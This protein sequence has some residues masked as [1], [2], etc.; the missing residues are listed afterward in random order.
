MKKSFYMNTIAVLVMVF[1]SFTT[2]FAKTLTLPLDVLSY[3]IENDGYY[4]SLNSDN[5]KVS[6]TYD[7]DSIDF[8]YTVTKDEVEKVYST[9][10]ELK[11]NVLYYTYKG[12]KTDL[13]QIELDKIAFETVFYAVGELNALQRSFLED[14]NKD[15]SRYNYDQYGIEVKTFEYGNGKKGIESFRLHTTEISAYG[16]SV[17]TPPTEEIVV[18]EP[19][20]KGNLVKTIALAIIFVLVVLLIIVLAVKTKKVKIEKKATNKKTATKKTTVKRTK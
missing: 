17:T 3:T 8:K 12:D 9:S 19:V 15:F 4:K 18:A 7:A 6:Y 1:F 5:A 16:T 20:P 11:D 14:M 10:F 13:T 2:V